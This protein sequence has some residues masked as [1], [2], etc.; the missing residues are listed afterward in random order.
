[1]VLL[2]LKYFCLCLAIAITGI[3]LTSLA[4]SC[5]FLS[6]LDP[7]KNAGLDGRFHFKFEQNWVWFLVG[8][9]WAGFFFIGSL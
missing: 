2:V 5:T 6:I 1:M 4:I 7:E 8:L 3:Q 9:F